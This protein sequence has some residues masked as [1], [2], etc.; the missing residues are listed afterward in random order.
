MVGE[1]SVELDQLILDEMLAYQELATKLFAECGDAIKAACEEVVNTIRRQGRL[2]VAGNGGSASQADHIAGEFVGRFE[3]DRQ[4]YP[5]FSLA[6]SIASLTAIANDFSYEEVFAR[7]LRAFGQS[8]D[9]VIALTTSGKSENIICLINDAK[10]LG[11]RTV[12]LTG[13]YTDDVEPFSEVVVAVP[14]IEVARIQEAHLL[15]GHLMAA[16]GEAELVNM[17]RGK[18][19]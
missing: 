6:T 5:A 14:S 18:S 8:G 11:I 3:K 15:I 9:L 10:G 1:R 16:S 17:Y 2:F 13:L 7:Q 4:P 19:S 12:C